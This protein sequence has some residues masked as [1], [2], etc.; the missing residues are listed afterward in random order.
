[1][2]APEKAGRER[3]RKLFGEKDSG[4]EVLLIYKRTQSKVQSLSA[5]QSFV[6]A[7]D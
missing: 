1:M 5:A 6:K 7:K 2:G 4:L 3:E